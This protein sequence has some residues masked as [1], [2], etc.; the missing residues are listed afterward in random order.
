MKDEMFNMYG[1][2]NPLFKVPEYNKIQL[3]EFERL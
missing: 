3:E 2:D 1:E